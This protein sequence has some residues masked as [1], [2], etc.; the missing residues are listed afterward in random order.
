[1]FAGECDSDG[2]AVVRRLLKY[3]AHFFASVDD[4]REPSGPL[5]TDVTELNVAAEHGNGVFVELMPRLP[6]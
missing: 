5:G 1:M 2:A 6:A 3:G 4:R